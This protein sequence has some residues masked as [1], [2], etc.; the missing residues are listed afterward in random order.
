MQFFAPDILEQARGLSVGLT[1]A[2]L[3]IG[4]LLWLTGWIGHRFWIVLAA[5]LVAGVFGLLSPAAG[6]VPP[7]V[8]GLL[9]AVAAGVLALALV[10]LVAFAAGGLAVWLA[11][12]TL[13][14]PAWDVPL[15]CL[16]G[17]GLVGLGLF[18]V[19]TMA[20]TSFAGTLLMGYCGLSLADYLGKLDAVAM[21]QQRVLLL[22]TFCGGLTLV[23]LLIQF[24]L[25]RRRRRLERFLENRNRLLEN[26]EL[27]HLY[28][29]R[30]W[31]FG[32]NT[33]RRAS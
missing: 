17:G 4:L 29:H 14:P 22:N 8:M 32:W 31:N 19:W 18:R 1:G 27:E 28:R 9:L 5:T 21:A 30:W 10:R 7:L 20:L 16:L 23:G 25:E 24:L 26:E 15:V 2:G 6:P 13:A 11:V 3:A 33:F 12:R